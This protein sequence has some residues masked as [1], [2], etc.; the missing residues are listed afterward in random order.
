MGNTS[1]KKK[2]HCKILQEEVNIYK[3]LCNEMTEMIIEK[4]ENE[5]KLKKEIADLKKMINNDLI[6][7]NRRQTI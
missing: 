7:I 3:N 4:S 1:A 5:K 6:E 2:C